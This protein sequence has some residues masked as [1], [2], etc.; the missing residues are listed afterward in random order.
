M[1]FSLTK[2]PLKERILHAIYKLQTQQ[3]KLEEASAKLHQRDREM[4]ERCVGAKAAGDDARAAIY[5]NECVEIRKMAKIVM[6]SQLAIEKAILRLQTIEDVGDLLVQ[7]TPVVGIIRETKGKIKGIIPE[8]AYELEEVNRMLN[9]TLTETGKVLPEV[10]VEEEASD[11]AK[12]IL[13]EASMLAEQKIEE[14]YP[15]LPLPPEPTPKTPE[16]PLEA[17]EALTTPP[18]STPKKT[19]TKVSQISEDELKEK[20]LSYLKQHGGELSIEKCA[21]TL[22]VTVEDV[23]KALS[24]LE[25][26]GKI[27]VQ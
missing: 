2:P 11:E 5:A 10:S 7:M 24:L 9:N 20:V 21:S 22:N 1:R 3:T 15:K 27:I 16:Q 26:E 18:L 17:L 4:F 14:R 8:V 13:A 19:I 6:F 25:S 12:K 23:K